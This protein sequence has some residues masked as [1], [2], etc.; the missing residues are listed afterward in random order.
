MSLTLEVLPH[1]WAAYGR[2]SA[3]ECYPFLN[4]EPAPTLATCSAC[5]S[6]IEGEDCKQ[7]RDRM[8]EAPIFCGPI[9][10]LF[11]P[12]DTTVRGLLGLEGSP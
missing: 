11:E 1:R 8:D 6:Y 10:H 4:G 3:A 2:T 5:V 9:C 7:W 12:N